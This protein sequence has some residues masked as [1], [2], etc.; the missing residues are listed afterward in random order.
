MVCHT[1]HSE[2]VYNGVK[3]RFIWD[4]SIKATPPIILGIGNRIKYNWIGTPE[5]ALEVASGLI[6][7]AQ[8]SNVRA[9][10]TT[11]RQAV[12]GKTAERPGL[13]LLGV[14][15]EGRWMIWKAVFL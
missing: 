2:G 10:E 3:F 15:V 1:W 4:K 12:W 7:T 6:N 13:G 8:A 9:M 14:G 5:P 11:T